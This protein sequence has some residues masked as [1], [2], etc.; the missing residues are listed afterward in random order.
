MQD[1]FHQGHTF[2]PACPSVEPLLTA[3]VHLLKY[4]QIGL[5][6]AV[7]EP[8]GDHPGS[9]QILKRDRRRHGWLHGPR[10]ACTVGGCRSVILV[11]AF[12]PG[13]IQAVLLDEVFGFFEGLPGLIPVD[14]LGNEAR[15]IECLE[16][17]GGIEPDMVINVIKTDV[18]VADI[19]LQDIPHQGGCGDGAPLCKGF[20]SVAQ[21][22]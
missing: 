4:R 7:N 19:A 22:R 16:G 21:V 13:T 15:Q 10:L 2:L 20:D 11:P 18:P 12:C 17:E 5:A 6:V 1:V 14:T 8:G 9:L 3:P